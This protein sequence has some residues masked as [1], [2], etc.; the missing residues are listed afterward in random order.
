M[1]EP[2]AQWP[3]TQAYAAS[4][5]FP[6]FV[7]VA[8]KRGLLKV[9]MTRRLS[10]AGAV[11]VDDV[12]K[13]EEIDRFWEAFEARTGLR[14]DPLHVNKSRAQAYQWDKHHIEAMYRRFEVDF[15]NVNYR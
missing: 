11:I 5:C 1:S 4:T 13:L 12:F 7:D 15:V 3:V 8:L 10:R 2:F 14:L 6:E 9:T